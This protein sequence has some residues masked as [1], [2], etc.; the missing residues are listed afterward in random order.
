MR[1]ENS[2]IPCRDGCPVQV[3]P[4]PP[5]AKNL[6][7]RNR[8]VYLYTYIRMKEPG[9]FRDALALGD[10]TD[11]SELWEWFASLSLQ[12]KPVDYVLLPDAAHFVVKPW[13]RIVAQQGLVDWFRFWLMG[14]EDT[15]PS[16]A[17]QYVRWRKLRKLQEE[18]EKKSVAPGAADRPLSSE[19]RPLSQK[20]HAKRG[21][22]QQT[23]S[24]R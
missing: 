11:V 21:E 7:R 15:D 2:A 24:N 12:K 17:D 5:S 14:E 3:I 18:S 16:K 4:S 1:S 22:S 6:S 13:E 20:C 23:A 19:H 8:A 10:S 9:R